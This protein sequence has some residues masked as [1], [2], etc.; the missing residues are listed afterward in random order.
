MRRAG[1]I[2]LFILLSASVLA[3]TT[4]VRGRVTDAE[5]G[6]GI[7]FAG[8]YFKDT[9][10]GVSADID[11][12]Y[13]LDTRDPAA[14]VLICQILGYES[15]ERTVN[16]GA[17]NQVDFALRLMDNELSGVVVKADNRKIR[18]LLDGID[19]N[20]ERLDPE[21]RP[22]YTCDVYS[23]TEL[24][25]THAREQLRGKRFLRELGF[26]FDYMDT[27]VVSGVPYLPVMISESVVRRTHSLDPA[28]DR[29]TVEANQISGIDPESNINLLSQFTGSLHLK[30]NF[31]KPFINA[32]GVE[33]PSPIQ[34][35]GLL[36]YNYYVVDSLQVDGRK[37]Y[38]VHY[39][40]KGGISSP[41]FEGEMRIDAEDFA[42]RTIHARMKHGGNVN[43][44]RDIVIDA[45]YE[46]LPDSTW[47]Y[48]NDRLY[49][50]FSVALR[51]SSKVMSMLGT[52]QLHYSNPSFLPTENLS[53]RAKVQ[54]DRDAGV[55]GEEYWASARPFELTEREKNIY[56]MVDEIQDMPI[57][58]TFY[59]VVYTALTGY[60]DLG[61]VGFGPYHKIIGFNNLEGFRP[62]LGIHTTKEL[63]RKFRWTAFIAYGFKDRMFKG[64]LSYERMFSREPTR[65]LTLD[66]SYDVFQIGRGKGEFTDGNILTSLLG[67]GDAQRLCPL[68]SISAKYEHEFTPGFNFQADAA[69]KRYFAN[70]YVP[71][72][73]PDGQPVP[74]VTSNELHLQ[75]R[76]SRDETVNRGHFIKRSIHTVHPILTLELTGGIPGIFPGDYGFFRP[77]VSLDWKVQTPPL[78]M[79]RLHVN[80]GTILGQVPYPLLH[81]HEGNGTYVLDKTAF[82]CMDFFEFV[83]DTWVSVFWNHN[84]N[85]FFLGK[86]PLLRK[87][88]LREEF[89]FKAAYGTLRDRNNP[90]VPGSGAPM[91]FPAG[92]KTLGGVPYVEVGAGIS[93]ILRFLRVDCFWRLTHRE[94]E[95]AGE[96]VTVPHRFSV[97]VGAE[98]R[99]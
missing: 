85:G 57:Y 69:V 33:F 73:S 88:N 17:F 14:Q 63:S 32:F 43:W 64:G 39:R 15:E 77:E 58:Q 62:R 90:D 29:E 26:I 94:H 38:V 81:V 37:T 79:T 52:R 51:D 84:F 40:P 82:S 20:R 21:L 30:I 80:A 72:F 24:D 70:A 35:G 46:R 28:T 3:Q 4:K 99:F 76:F 60:L 95:I 34:R 49:A 18:R 22:A 67:K 41:A 71:M 45:D 6:E 27:S 7:P 98:F 89:T 93:N 74:Y 8:V 12:Y 50:D 97:T 86:I 61:P 56:K 42:L 47:F 55:R 44:L 36:Y 9:Q 31:Y 68:L 5:T 2:T 59:D 48:S 19:G 66:A 25:L 1:L 96:M 54:V 23:R 78:G 16:A 91:A 87:L 53:A 11:G 13:T 75:A 92:M 65:K 10:I 83:S